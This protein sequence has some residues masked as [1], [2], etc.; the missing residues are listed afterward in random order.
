MND[1]Q[2]FLTHLLRPILSSSYFQ[3]KDITRKVETHTLYKH[4]HKKLTQH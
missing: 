1:K 2:T 4:T 3:E